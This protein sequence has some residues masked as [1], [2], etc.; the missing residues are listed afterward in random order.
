MRRLI[1]PRVI[2][3]AAGDTSQT[4]KLPRLPHL[5][6]VC[7]THIVARCTD[8]ATRRIHMYIEV[9][10]GTSLLVDKTPPANYDS[11]S[12]SGTLFLLGQA[13]ICADFYNVD[14]GE[15]LELAA[16]GYEVSE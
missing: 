9:G 15:A 4:V 1:T 3:V 12:V 8:K 2:E 6:Q 13:Q 7:W 14:V 10:A 5:D 16:Y 11:V